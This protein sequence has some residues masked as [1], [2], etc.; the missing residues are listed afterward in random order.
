MP[1][2]RRFTATATYVLGRSSQPYGVAYRDAAGRR[3]IHVDT[4]VWTVGLSLTS[5]PPLP[6]T[7]PK[8]RRHA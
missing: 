3:V 8:D 4:R 7:T 5:A 2:L 1:D 6:R